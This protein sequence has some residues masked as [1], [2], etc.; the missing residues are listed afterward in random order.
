M[1]I[2]SVEF[3]LNI[4]SRELGLDKRLAGSKN[5]CNNGVQAWTILFTTKDSWAQKYCRKELPKTRDLPG[6]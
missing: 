5:A 1:N 2:P 6:L 4:S 3:G